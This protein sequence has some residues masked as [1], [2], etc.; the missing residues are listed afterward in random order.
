[1]RNLLNF[2]A[3][4][5]NLIIF[6]FLE[7]IAIYLLVSGNNYHN[8]RFIKG[9]RWAT[10]GIDKQ[11]DYTRTY[12]KLRTINEQLAEENS[13]LKNRIEKMKRDDSS[14]FFSVTDTLYRQKYTHT[15]A[16]VIN[17][18]T[19]R[20]KNF[21]TLNKGIRHGLRTD[22]AVV[23]SGSV[24]GII[25]SCSENFSIAMSLLNIDFK[26]SAR[27]KENGYFGSLYWDGRDYRTAL[28]GEIPQHVIVNAGDTIETT[29][30]SV[31]F[32]EG[33]MIGRVSNCEKVGG[34]FYR[35][36]VE[37]STDFKKLHFV[38]IIG[39]MKKLE[40][41]QLESKFQ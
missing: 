16:E 27:I 28:L 13:L 19:N 15:S 14:L 41:L 21:F 29:G 36:S 8:T 40:Q 20:Q 24:A 10:A 33:V 12:L 6:L 3:R 17:N 22:M 34:N 26:L 38:D 2:L 30:Y 5:N 31:I 18:S 35:I 37:L 4:Y 11:V 1:M 9:L 39:N 25:I 7:G 32:P 23:S